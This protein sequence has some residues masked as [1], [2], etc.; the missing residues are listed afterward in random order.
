MTTAKFCNCLG[1]VEHPVRL[2][3]EKCKFGKDRLQAKLALS[4]HWVSC[5]KT[6]QQLSSYSCSISTSS[7]LRNVPV[8]NP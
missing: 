3:R 1:F 8:E 2:P 5:D 7:H 6:Q 4:H